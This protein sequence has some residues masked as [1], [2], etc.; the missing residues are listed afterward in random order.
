LFILLSACSGGSAGH[1]PKLNHLSNCSLLPKRSK[2]RKI[3]S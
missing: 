3:L 2:R 1:C